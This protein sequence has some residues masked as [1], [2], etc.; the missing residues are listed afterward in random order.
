MQNTVAFRLSGTE[1]LKIQDFS[2]AMAGF[3]KYALC[4][5]EARVSGFAFRAAC[6]LTEAAKALR[7]SATNAE[8][9]RARMSIRA[10]AFDCL[11]WMCLIDTA[12]KAS[13]GEARDTA[14]E[15][16]RELIERI[17]GT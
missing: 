8:E 13:W 12:G 7:Y 3:Y 16:A 6:R 10:A 4:Q 2:T 9:F 1:L 5:G 15:A 17:D 11:Y 14:M